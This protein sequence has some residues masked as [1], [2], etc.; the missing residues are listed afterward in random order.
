MTCRSLPPPFAAWRW[1]AAVGAVAALLDGCTRQEAQPAPGPLQVSALTVEPRDTPVQ[2]EFVAQTQS[3]REVQIQARVEG[4]LDRRLYTEGDMVRA[5]QPLFQMDR[6]PFEAAL[7]SAQ[8]QLEQQKARHAVASANLAR[9]RPLAARNAVSKKELDDA[10]GFER[11]SQA[12]VLAAEGQVR[13]ANLNL[14]YTTIYS[15]LKGLSSFAKQQEG[16][17][18]TVGQQGLLTTV[19]QID[20]IWVNFSVSENQQLSYRDQIAKGK[21]RFPANLQF[22]VEVVMADGSIFPHRGHINFAA[23]SFDPATGTFLVRTELP[24]PDGVLRPGQ[25]VRARVY[26]STRPAAIR[27]PQ[28]AVQQGAK[29]HYVWVVGNDGKARQRVVEVGDWYGDEWFISDGLKSGERVVVDGA[30]RVA[31]N[32]PL[33]VTTFAPAPVVASTGAGAPQ[34][35]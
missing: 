11:E 33:K 4:F 31:P 26:G 7:L 10:I 24:N 13:Q 35:R 9:V 8:G 15:P 22:T 2:F 19:S 23:P 32:A 30:G 25:F 29:G 5:G 20:P 3:S 34:P 27:I 12:A 16:S 17:Y 21:L 18:L 28:R 6:K 1:L 14:G